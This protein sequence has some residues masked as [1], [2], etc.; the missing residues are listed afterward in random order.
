[1]PS[2]EGLAPQPLAYMSVKIATRPDS[3]WAAKTMELLPP[4]ESAEIR[5]GMA[6][7]RTLFNRR[8]TGQISIPLPPTAAGKVGFNA[9]PLGAR[10]LM[11]ENSPELLGTSLS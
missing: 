11:G 3:G 5:P 4:S 1:T 7:A 10:T 9:Q 6:L 8:T 2:L